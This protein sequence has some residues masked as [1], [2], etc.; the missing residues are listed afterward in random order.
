MPDFNKMLEMEYKKCKNVKGIAKTADKLAKQ[1]K[2]FRFDM[3]Q[4]LS[5]LEEEIL[6][7]KCSEDPIKAK[8]IEDYATEYKDIRPI[9]KHVSFNLG[10]L[11]NACKD[12]D[13]LEKDPGLSKANIKNLEN[14][15][16]DIDKIKKATKGKLDPTIKKLEGQIDDDLKEIND[17]LETI[18]KIPDGHRDPD[19]TYASAT[20][21]IMNA[22]PRLSP[23]TKKFNDLFKD[24]LEKSK[25]QKSIKNCKDSQKTLYKHTKVAQDYAEKGDSKAGIPSWQAGQSELSKIKV[26]VERYEHIQEK[27]K[28]E[29]DKSETKKLIND[30]IKKMVTAKNEMTK[31]AD[32]VM[33]KINKSNKKNEE[34][35]KK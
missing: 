22:K 14:I 24:M 32:A 21:D 33:A 5:A 11:Q 34:S 27:Y 4:G 18:K 26:L 19:K 3:T 6:E 9:M 7:K 30:S 16:K 28:S 1:I 12:L 17:V 20:K 13:K 2:Y 29:I 10:K 31:H 35:Q 25:L 15:K 8:K 23:K